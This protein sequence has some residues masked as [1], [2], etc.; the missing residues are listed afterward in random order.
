MFNNFNLKNYVE[1]LNKQHLTKTDQ[2]QLLSYG[3]LVE[4]HISHNKKEKYFSLIKWYLTKK[5]NPSTFRG[6]FLKMQKKD[7]DIVQNFH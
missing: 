4:R 1:L 6:K 5:I 3:T 7:D 2:L